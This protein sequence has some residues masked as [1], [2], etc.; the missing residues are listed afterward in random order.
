MSTGQMD[1][2]AERGEPL[3][4]GVLLD[5]EGRPTRDPEAWVEGL[6]VPAGGHRGSGL[7][8][9]FEILTGVLAGGDRFGP[10]VGSPNAAGEPQGVS[11]VTMAIDPTVSMPYEQFVDRVDR[12]IDAVHAAPPA[13]GTDR[14]NVPGERGFRTAEQRLRDGIPLAPSRVDALR[15]LGVD[16][17]VTL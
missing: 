15:A 4:E 14:V 12:V 6:L 8:I 2:L 1:L 11:L 17:G 9:M 3:P 5:A 16:L 7:A 13:A 10:D